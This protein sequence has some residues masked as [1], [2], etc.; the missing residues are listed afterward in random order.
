VFVAS[1]GASSTAVA[2]GSANIQGTITDSAS[3]RPIVGAQVA[4]AGTTRGTVTDDAGRFAVRGI[5]PGQ[6]VLRVVRLGYAA[7]ERRVS[8]GAN[9]TVNADFG[10]RTVATVLSEVVVTG[11]GTSSR[12]ELSSAVAQVSAEQIVGAPVAG[13]DAALQGKAP[14]VQVV[15]NAGNP[16]NG[17]T[18][19]VRGSSSLSATNQPLYV[20]DGIPMQSGDLSQLG[21]GGQDLTGVTGFCLDE[22][23][24][25]DFLKDA[26]ASAI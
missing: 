5:A 9:E 15:Q 6:Y 11:Y 10:L 13:L 22:I 19:R 3:Q 20:V 21:F 17:I 1:I 14:G 18:V 4:I 24:T 23:E 26:A 25:I 2:Q 16:G 12:A 8:V 7:A